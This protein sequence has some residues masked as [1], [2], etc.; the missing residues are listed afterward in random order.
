MNQRPG[1]SKPATLRDHGVSFTTVDFFKACKTA[2]L[3]TKNEDAAF[4]FEQI[5]EHLR[6]G[7]FMDPKKASRILGL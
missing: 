2:L 1:K 6:T 7:G 4:Y 3:E 5:E